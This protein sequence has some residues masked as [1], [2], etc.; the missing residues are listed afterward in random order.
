[1]T[2]VRGWCIRLFCLTSLIGP[3]LLLTGCDQVYAQETPARELVVATKEAAPFAIKAP[4]GTW[5]GISIELWRKIAEQAKLSYRFVEDTSVEGLL[6]GTAAG[7]YDAAVAALTITAERDRILDFSQPFYLSGLGIAV[8]SAS[9]T[10]WM[11]IVRTL[12]SV[13][14]L[15]AILA[16]IG[17]TLV[18]GLLI[19][20]IERRHNEDFGGGVI[21]GLGTSIWWSAEAMTQASTGHLTPKTGLGRALAILWMVASIVAIAVFTASVTSTL[22]AGKLQ[23]LVTTVNDLTSVRVGAVQGSATE[24]YLTARRIPYRRFPSPQGG[25]A[26]IRNGTLDAFVYDKPLLAWIVREQFASSIT[27]LDLTFDQQMYGI[28]LPLG[29]RSTWRCSTRSRESGGARRYSA[30]LA[31]DEPLCGTNVRTGHNAEVNRTSASNRESRRSNRA[32][33]F[34]SLI[35]GRLPEAFHSNSRNPDDWRYMALG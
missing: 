13:G 21:K 32:G 34:Q 31:S 33:E 1:M 23:G 27:M 5:K 7:R 8:P 18:V 6:E 16:L 15:Q 2:H 12:T 35:H 4:D 10:A 19:W 14:F 30:T 20:F 26:A 22:T 9:P 3:G 11:L 29:S 17:L 25:L 24:Q 28:A